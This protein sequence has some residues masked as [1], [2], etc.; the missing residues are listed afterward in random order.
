MGKFKSGGIHCIC[1]NESQIDFCGN[2]LPLPL[3]FCTQKL[4]ST[5][6]EIKSQTIKS[7]TIKSW[8]EGSSG[9]V[10]VVIHTIIHYTTL[11]SN[12]LLPLLPRLPS[13]L[14]YLLITIRNIHHF[15]P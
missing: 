3:P 7:Q 9:V 2:N 11:T 6:I 1:G 4:N 15:R 12:L 14:H 5:Q 10:E 8:C 13:Y